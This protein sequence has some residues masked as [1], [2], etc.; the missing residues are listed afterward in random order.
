MGVDLQRL[1]RPSMTVGGAQPRGRAAAGL[2]PASVRDRVSAAAFELF[3]DRGYD[4]TTVDHIAERSG[5]ARRTFFRYFRSKD[6]V[7]FPDHGRLLGD[8]Q[9]FLSVAAA[10][11]PVQAVCGGVRLVLELYM[12]DPA[13]SVQR[14]QLCRRVPQLRQR[15]VASVADYER[16]F[17]HYLRERLEPVPGDLPP[18]LCADVVAAAVVAAHNTVL[19]DWLRAGGRSD[20]HAGLD[21][22]LGYVVRTFT[23]AGAAAAPAGPDRDGDGTVVAVF[24]APERFDDVVHRLRRQLTEG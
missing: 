16:A 22:A 7:I 18:S 23:A 3:G 13:V 14:Y 6:D 21:A 8:V 24:R 9:R 12:R 1:Y 10:G 5:I 20:A 11:S 2:D 19:R 4:G 17:S 15:E